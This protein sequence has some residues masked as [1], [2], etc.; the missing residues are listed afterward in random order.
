MINVQ[1]RLL[2]SRNRVKAAASYRQAYRPHK[3]DHYMFVVDGEH[4]QSEVKHIINH[5]ETQKRSEHGHLIDLLV[6]CS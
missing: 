1:Y 5:P 3:G 6:V 2:D 4:I